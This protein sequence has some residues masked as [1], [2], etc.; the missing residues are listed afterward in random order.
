MIELNDQSLEEIQVGQKVKFKVV[1]SKSMIENFAILSGDYNPLHME[2]SY[3]KDA[4]FEKRI[5]H[6][7]LLASLFSRLIGMYLPGKNALYLS[8][9]LKFVSPCFVDDEVTIEGKVLKK[10]SSTRIITLETKIT[11]ESN[12]NIVIGEAK[13]MVRGTDIVIR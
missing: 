2:D 1:I 7:M 4:G 9:S 6:G 11:K 3:A 5:C 8:Q 12:I 13:V 10:S